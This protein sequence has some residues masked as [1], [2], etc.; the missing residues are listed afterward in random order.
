MSDNAENTGT[1]RLMA[2]FRLGGGT[3]C[4]DTKSVQEVLRV[5]PITPVHDA[6]PSVLGV[7][8]LRGRIATVIDLGIKLELGPVTPGPEN[9]IFIVDAHGEQVGLLVD[10]VADAIEVDPGAVEPPPGNVNGVQKQQIRGVVLHA[11]GTIAMLD[12][13]QILAAGEAE[14]AALAG[15]N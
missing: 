5:G 7:M 9:R 2:T 6:P 14:T 8:N 13:D 1:A 4:I 15:G 12:T 11:H 10:L 3:F